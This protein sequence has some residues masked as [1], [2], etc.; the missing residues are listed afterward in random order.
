MLSLK[1]IFKGHNYHKDNKLFTKYLICST[2]GHS[3]RYKGRTI[4][5]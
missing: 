5:E 3:R 4:E 1:C 2:C